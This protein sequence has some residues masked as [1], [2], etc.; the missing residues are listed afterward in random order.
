MK[1]NHNTESPPE[2]LVLSLINATNKMRSNGNREVQFNNTVPTVAQPKDNIMMMD[3]TSLNNPNTMNFRC[4]GYKDDYVDDFEDDNLSE[5]VK[6][7]YI[8]QDGLNIKMDM[9]Q[10]SEPGDEIPE[11]SDFD[12]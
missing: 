12:F 5:K 1:S 4:D 10:I 2:H 3:N 8:S 6:Q 9:L 7:P 11:D